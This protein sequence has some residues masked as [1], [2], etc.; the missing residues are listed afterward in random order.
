MIKKGPIG[1][2]CGI[3]QFTTKFKCVIIVLSNQTWLNYYE[4]D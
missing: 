3:Y 2:F 4:T 1:P